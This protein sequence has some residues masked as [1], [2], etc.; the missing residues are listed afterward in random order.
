MV[1]QLLATG[2]PYVNFPLWQ[3]CG[4]YTMVILWSAI[5]VLCMYFILW[6]TCKTHLMVSQLQA[7]S[8]P[9]ADYYGN[10]VVSHQCSMYVDYLMGHLKNLPDG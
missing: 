5:S 8:V 2:V 7:T 6:D 4:I 3:A 9:Y 1:S 10:Y